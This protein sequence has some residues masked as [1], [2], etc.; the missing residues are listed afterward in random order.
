[1]GSSVSL[2]VGEESFNSLNRKTHQKLNLLFYPCWMK[3]YSLFHCISFQNYPFDPLFFFSMSVP[4]GY[5]ESTSNFLFMRSCLYMYVPSLLSKSSLLLFT[6]S[7]LFLV[8][9]VMTL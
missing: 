5:C 2:V 9:A 7:S 3:S 6:V 1:M 4:S 8:E